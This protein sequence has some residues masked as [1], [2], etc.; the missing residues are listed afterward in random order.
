MNIQILNFKFQIIALVVLATLSVVGSILLS[1]SPAAGF[2][3]LIKIV[4][5]T[6]FGFIIAKNI[7]TKKDFIVVAS[8]FAAGIIFESFL[9]IWQFINQ[10]SIGGIFWFFGERTFSGQTVGIA[11]ANIDGQLILRPYGT[12]PHPN[13]L[14]GY[15][16]IALAMVISNFQFPISNFKKA[17]FIAVLTIGTVALFLTLSRVAI[18]VWVAVMGLWFLI[19][20]RKFLFIGLLVVLVF[21]G[22]IIFSPLSSRFM[23]LAT[24]DKE[25]FILRQQLNNSAIEMFKQSPVWGVGLN[26]FL[27]NLPRYQKPQAGPLWLQP[28]HNIFLLVAAE[29]GLIGL[30]FFA[31]FIS[32]TVIKL[33]KKKEFQISN[34]KFQILI[35]IFVLGLFD[36]YFWTLQQGQLL[37]AL[38]F[39]LCWSKKVQETG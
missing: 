35:I 37:L 33:R 25:S 20:L 3:K 38:V 18:I 2:Y 24:V 29:T 36:H 32:R 9:A 12:F 23:S 17:L 27:M 8:L 5:L 22:S 6:F 39:G 30:L 13:V 28:V 11:N 16:T 19:N 10:S 26:N 21:I 31:W 34:F 7:N 4:E 1:L 15:L 14:A